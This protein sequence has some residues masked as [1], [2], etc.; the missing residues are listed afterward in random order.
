MLTKKKAIVIL[1]IGA[2]H[3]KKSF[4]DLDY[5]T[6]HSIS[7]YD[8]KRK[9]PNSDV[10]TALSTKD[11]AKIQNKHIILV[12]SA[13]FD[14]FK[15]EKWST[16]DFYFELLQFIH[17][18]KNPQEVREIG[19]KR[20]DYKSLS[21]ASKIDI[22]FTSMPCGKL[23][24]AVKTGEA[25]SSQ[26]AL[27]LMASLVNKI[28]I[29]DP[30]PPMEFSFMEKLAKSGKLEKISIVN[31]LREKIMSK[32]S[33]KDPIEVT[34]DEFGQLRMKMESL[35]KIRKDSETVETIGNIN[36]N[37]RDVV[38]IDDMLLTGGTLRA[39]VAKY[40]ELGANQVLVG[41]VHALPIE[42][43]NDNR[44]KMTLKDIRTLITSDTVYSSFIEDLRAKDQLVSCVPAIDKALKK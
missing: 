19:H 31:D 26:M 21:P 7:N 1:G 33:P 16:A 18:L 44:L 8:G 6:M 4:E 9:F 30:H 37:K 14:T 2:M 12:Q 10:Y 23:D 41:I 29:I 32:Y 43:E 42:K 5:Q 24:H 34:A 11:L 20:F 17:L 38:F 15:D 36:V 35:G 27:E 3:L 22:V 13:S 40:K 25:V 39:N 28:Y